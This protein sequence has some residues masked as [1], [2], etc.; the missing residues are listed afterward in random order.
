MNCKNCNGVMQVDVK[1]KLLVCPYCGST[2]LLD[3]TSKEEIQELL[4]D[5]LEDANREN[6]QMIQQML[7]AQ[8]REMA[9]AHQANKGKDVAIFVGLAIAGLFTLI[10]AMFG[11][12]TD[13]Y[14]A[15]AVIALIQ[16]ILFLVAFLA[17]TID[18]NYANKKAANVSNICAIAGMLL[19]I[20][21][22]FALGA[23]SDNSSEKSYMDE[24]Y[25]REY[26]WPTEG[27]AACVPKI[28]EHPDYAYDGEREFSA[29]ILHATDETFN[30]YV[31]EAKKCGFT[32]DV[33]VDASSYNAYNEAGNELDVSFLEGAETMY[34]K[35]FPVR[36]F[37]NMIW[38][39]QGVMKDVPQPDSDE[40]FVESMSADYF[41]AFVNNMTQDKYV[42]YIQECINAG[43]DG[44]YESGSTR[45]YAGKGNTRISLELKRGRVMA[46]SVY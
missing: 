45:F 24:I 27:K 37:G 17:K 44:R 6:R 9:L 19:V 41:N 2:E 33:T 35:L 28:G 29:T 8:Q 11:F 21:W 10:M 20:V 39:T 7:T 32:I 34:V 12:D 40:L 22:I 18:H 26:D 46:I 42:A 1:A 43:F 16:F 38:P 31:E 13:G 15:S 3:N 25:A 5:A 4:K 14:L 30:E 36:E 23:S